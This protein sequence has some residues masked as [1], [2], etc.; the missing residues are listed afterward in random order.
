[1]Y[2]TDPLP[3][4][5]DITIIHVTEDTDGTTNLAFI[6]SPVVLNCPSL[7]YIITSN[8]GLCPNAT[9]MTTIKCRGI[10]VGERCTLTVQSEVCGSI[11]GNATT[12]SVDLKGIHRIVT[13]RLTI[14][15][16]L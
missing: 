11:I 15:N 9:S 14:I 1:M 12:I 2:I 10:S 4:P 8:C 7:R 3:P 6:W 16:Y 5:N 13:S